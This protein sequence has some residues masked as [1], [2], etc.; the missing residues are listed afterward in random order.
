MAYL[1]VTHSQI[2]PA[3]LAEH[4]AEL[5]RLS[6]ELAE[7]VRRLPGC[8]H[9]VSGGDFATGRSISVSVFDTLEHAQLSRASLGAMIPR[10]QALG[11]QIES[12][13]FYEVTS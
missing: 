3:R 4:E 6:V 13:A 11:L 7:A 10:M 12:P 5:R 1:R 8:L 2:D 9:Y